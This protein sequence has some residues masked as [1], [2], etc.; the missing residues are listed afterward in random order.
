MRTHLTSGAHHGRTGRLYVWGLSLY[1]WG[2]SRSKCKWRN[3]LALR[4]LQPSVTPAPARL[5]VGGPR[6]GHDTALASGRQ[7][8]RW[9]SGLSLGYRVVC[10]FGGLDGGEA[11]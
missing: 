3:R 5:A 7:K 1:V 6:R 11:P 8:R 10:A 9:S 4:V 2:L